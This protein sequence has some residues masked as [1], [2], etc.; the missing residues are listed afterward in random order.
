MDVPPLCSSAPPAKGRLICCLS[1]SRYASLFRR[2][3]SADATTAPILQSEN[4]SACVF[5]TCIILSPLARSSE[6]P[7]IT[8]SRRAAEHKLRHLPDAA[9]FS[10]VGNR[11]SAI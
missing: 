6:C 8:Y 10:F 9:R 1:V 3:P 11:L 2:G 5:D 4:A 7:A